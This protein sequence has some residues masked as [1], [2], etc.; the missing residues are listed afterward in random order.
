MTGSKTGFDAPCWLSGGGES[1]FLVGGSF[2][3]ILACRRKPC[4]KMFCDRFLRS[5]NSFTGRN[6][7]NL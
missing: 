5:H 1:F 2:L 6:L 4:A 7:Y 3:G